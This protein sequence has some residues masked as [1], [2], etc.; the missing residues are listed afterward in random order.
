MRIGMRTKF[1]P[2]Q[3]RAHCL[4]IILLIVMSGWL[5]TPADAQE[6]TVIKVV[7]AESRPFFFSADAESSYTGFMFEL[8]EV[9]AM[10][11]GVEY[12]VTLA[13]TFADVLESVQMGVADIAVLDISISAEREAQ[14][15][16]SHVVLNDGYQIITPVGN[17]GNP[18]LVTILAG[19]TVFRLLGVVLPMMLVVAHF[20]WLIERHNNEEFDKRYPQGVWDALWWAC[21]TMTGV[22]YGNQ[23][24]RRAIGR[25]L[26]IVWMFISIIVVSLFV[27]EMTTALTVSRLDS[28]ISSP[29]DLDG[30]RVATYADS[31]YQTF[32]ETL[33]VQVILFE[34]ED[35]LF[36][37]LAE[38]QVDAAIVGAT[39]AAYYIIH[40]GDG[41]IQ[42]AGN[43]FFADTIAFA[44]PQNSPYRERVN[45]AL[46]QMR[47]SGQ[48]AEIYARWFGE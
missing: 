40:Q 35:E 19:T 11:L 38:N 30:L 47:E 15:D 48:Y 39:R 4:W 2:T 44:F 41:R 36:T 25:I 5:Y 17:A 31:V 7:S 45:T 37:A 34:D 14:M 9:I 8:W 20:M 6:E 26:A 18:N 32:V 1:L 3:I 46:L 22:G 24:P 28:G 13:D 21:V 33:P 16:F 29:S 23:E 10:Q 43:A 12:E 27:A 42:L